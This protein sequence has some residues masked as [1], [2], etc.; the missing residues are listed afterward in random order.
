MK[1][2][3]MKCFIIRKILRKS[4]LLKRDFELVVTLDKTEDML[5]IRSRIL[6][7]LEFELTCNEFVMLYTQRNENIF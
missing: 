4:R 7:L 3:W 6:S 2:F 1:N 5:V